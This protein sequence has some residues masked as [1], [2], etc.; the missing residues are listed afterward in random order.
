MSAPGTATVLALCLGVLIA[1]PV[2]A[3]QAP[4]GAESPAGA[5][6]APVTASDEAATAADEGAGTEEGAGEADEGDDVFV[7]SV[8]VSEDD[9]VPFPVDI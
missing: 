7:P 5:E 3:A 4:A 1:M 6:E 2:R 9:S 8:E